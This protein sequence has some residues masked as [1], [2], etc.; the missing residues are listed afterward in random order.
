MSLDSLIDL[1]ARQLNDHQ[2]SSQ[3]IEHPSYVTW[4]RPHI[5]GALSMALGYLLS[6]KPDTFSRIVTYVTS[7]TSCYLKLPCSKV[8]D[9]LQVGTQCNNAHVIETSGQISLISLLTATCHATPT[10]PQYEFVNKGNGIYQVTPA[11]PKGTTIT[12][13]CS[14]LPSLSQIDD[15]LL[16]EYQPLLLNFA[17][18]FLL[19][20]D[21][22]SR[23]NLDRAQ[24][25]YTA[26]K[27]FVETK[28]LIEFSLREDDYLYGRRK[29]DDP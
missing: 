4:V 22:E 16:T 7:E 27:D 13:L 5:E 1:I 26:V 6:I 19:L 10:N 21:N 11:I 20:T 23:S 2:D 18:W 29:V 12:F 14:S 24:L 3:G 17:L 8:L 9:V 28:L 25:Y 15:G